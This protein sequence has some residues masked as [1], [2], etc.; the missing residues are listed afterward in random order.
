MHDSKQASAGPCRLRAL[1]PV[2]MHIPQPPG[3]GWDAE[4]IRAFDRLLHPRSQRIALF[5][6]ESLS[7]PHHLPFR[8][9]LR[10]VRS[11]PFAVTERVAFAVAEPDKRE[12]L[13]LRNMIPN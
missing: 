12:R 13:A 3:D 1:H 2:E 11:E 9:I 7:P 10:E 6:G 8:G 5:R 4:P